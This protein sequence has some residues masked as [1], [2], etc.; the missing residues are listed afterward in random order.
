MKEE[1][2]VEVFR[3]WLLSESWSEVEPTD[4]W[5]DIEAVRGSQRL[6]CEVKGTTTDPGVDADVAYG[7]L[8]RRMTDPSPGIRYALVVPTSALKAALRVPWQVRET[9]RIEVYEVRDDGS[10]VQH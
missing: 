5:T 6:V 2:V 7:Q 8:L 4:P 9:N 3:G 10:V 1:R